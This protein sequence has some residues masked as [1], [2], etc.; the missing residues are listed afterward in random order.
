MI[1]KISLIFHRQLCNFTFE[2][3]SELDCLDFLVWLIE[4]RG[5]LICLDFFIHTEVLCIE[6]IKNK[7]DFCLNFLFQENEKSINLDLK[8]EHSIYLQ[9]FPE[10][11]QNIIVYYKLDDSFSNVGFI[12]FKIH[13]KFLQTMDSVDNFTSVREENLQVIVNLLL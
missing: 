12:S 13:N 7:L 8:Q 3:D 6:D 10:F 9:L 2:I 5:M 11:G 4:F 1:I